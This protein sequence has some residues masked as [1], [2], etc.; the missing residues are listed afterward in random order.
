MLRIYSFKRTTVLVGT[1]IFSGLAVA[2]MAQSVH[3]QNIAAVRQAVVSDGHGSRVFRIDSSGRMTKAGDFILEIT[4]LTE[5]TNNSAALVG[6]YYASGSRSVPAS[7][8]VTGSIEVTNSAIRISF[9]AAEAVG[10]FSSLTVF[11]GAIRLG[12]ARDP[13]FG[14]MAG[15]FNYS[16]SGAGTPRGPFPFCARL[17]SVTPG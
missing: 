15:T 11:E 10:L 13:S 16:D 9:T 2:M 14:F 7:T 3:A 17:S 6:K 1:M 5:L 8:N 12:G 4:R